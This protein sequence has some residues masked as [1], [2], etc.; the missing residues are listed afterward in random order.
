M[1]FKRA[2]AGLRILTDRR[3]YH[4]AYMDLPLEYRMK[5][6]SH[7]RGGI[8][9]DASE[10]GFHVSSTEDFPMGTALKIAVLFSDK[11]ELADFKVFA[12]IVWKKVTSEKRRKAYQYG[13]KFI[14]ISEEDYSKLRKLLSGRLPSEEVPVIYEVNPVRKDGALTH[15]LSE[16]Y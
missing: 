12:Q 6:D 13:L 4:R 5:Y 1:D 7:A 10:T 8:L 3:K 16:P 11:Y 15:A 9:I 2:I 14:E